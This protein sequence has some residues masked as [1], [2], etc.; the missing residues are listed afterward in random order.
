MSAERLT[1][2]ML[3][4]RTFSGKGTIL[5]ASFVA[6][7]SVMGDAEDLILFDSMSSS[8]ESSAL[9]FIAKG[10]CQLRYENESCVVK[11]AK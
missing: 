9:R 5:G 7:R 10:E 2:G 1:D 4:I 11:A 3:I 6:A 8:G